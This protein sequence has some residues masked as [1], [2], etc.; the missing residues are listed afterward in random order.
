VVVVANVVA[1]VVTAG[2]GGRR[3]G[4]GG[5]IRQSWRWGWSPSL[6]SG[7]QLA[8]LVIGADRGSHSRQNW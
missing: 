5:R 1:V 4:C 6:T 7:C 2:G 3:L 8:N